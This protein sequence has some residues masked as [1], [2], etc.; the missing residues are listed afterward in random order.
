MLSDATAKLLT[1]SLGVVQIVCIRAALLV[2]C[3]T[4]FFNA[5]GKRE[6]LRPGD[7]KM[8]LMRGTLPVHCGKVTVVVHEDNSVT[9]SD[10]GRGIPVDQCTCLYPVSYTHL[11]LPTIYSV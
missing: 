5:S 3:L 7:L 1:E 11:T 8:Q 6:I 9:V 10:D 4:V 2:T